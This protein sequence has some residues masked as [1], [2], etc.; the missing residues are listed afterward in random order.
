MKRAKRYAFKLR[1]SIPPEQLLFNHE[2][3]INLMYL[4]GTPILHIVDT[5]TEFRNETELFYEARLQ[6][7]SG[8]QF[9]NAWQLHI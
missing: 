1:E 9:W 2:I 3:A 8:E 7:M 6:T 5:H 4:E